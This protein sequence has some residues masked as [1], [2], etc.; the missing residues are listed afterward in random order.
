[1]EFKGT[2]GEWAIEGEAIYDPLANMWFCAIVNEEGKIL[3]RVYGIDKEEAEANAKLIAEAPKLLE[4]LQELVDLKDL[5][6]REGKE[7]LYKTKQP[8]AW[9]NA[10]KAIEKALN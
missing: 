7:G 10:R 1:M 4:T 5:K 6:D 3:Q 9:E 8:L 2:K